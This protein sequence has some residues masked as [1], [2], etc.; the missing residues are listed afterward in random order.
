MWLSRPCHKFGW[1][2]STT[3]TDPSGLIAISGY[4]L[5]YLCPLSNR[6]FP[7]LI[8]H[9][10]SF[11]VVLYPSSASMLM[12]NRLLFQCGYMPYLVHGDGA[13]IGQLNGNFSCSRDF[14]L[15]PVT[16]SDNAARFG[17]V[18]WEP[19]EIWGYIVV[20]TTIPRRKPS[21]ACVNRPLQV[22]TS[23]VV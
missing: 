7:R 3:F 17:R 5:L 1:V 9:V 2:F 13:A 8:I 19:L 23:F 16:E 22:G 18:V 20:K 14:A 15:V 6:R 10:D 12:K 11:R 21:I 4:K